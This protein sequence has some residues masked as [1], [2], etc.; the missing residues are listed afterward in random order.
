MDACVESSSS[1][2]DSFPPVVCTPCVEPISVVSNP[3]SDRGKES[4]SPSENIVLSP[5]NDAATDIALPEE[6]VILES[7]TGMWDPETTV[8][9]HFTCWMMPM[10]IRI[11]A[12]PIL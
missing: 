3:M 12:V 9:N 6:K 11:A 10:G 4:F 8:Y 5:S 2:E 7:N 1:K